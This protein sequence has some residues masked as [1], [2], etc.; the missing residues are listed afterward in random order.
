VEENNDDD[1]DDDEEDDEEEEGEHV[2]KTCKV[3]ARERY[4][5]DT[6]SS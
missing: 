3:A 6:T 2:K 5:R 1:D 4:S